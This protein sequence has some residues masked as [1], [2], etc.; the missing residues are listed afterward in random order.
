MASGMTNVSSGN[1]DPVTSG[2]PVAF[3]VA[4][5]SA[6]SYSTGSIKKARYNSDYFTYSSGTF[7]CKKA[8]TGK[9]YGY[10][11]GS[12]NTSGASNSFAWKVEKGST[13]IVSSS[14]GGNSSNSVSNVS[15]AV[16]S[17]I[18]IFG[19]CSVSG[20]AYGSMIMVIEI[21]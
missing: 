11:L 8:F 21:E 1:A 12:K 7:T 13:N 3:L 10:G 2:M 19:Q 5:T 9:V 6:T 20:T 16:G 14:G 17:T 15:F 4:I 18:N